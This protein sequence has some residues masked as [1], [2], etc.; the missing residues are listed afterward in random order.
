MR[1]GG[2]SVTA[3]CLEVEHGRI[4]RIFALRNPEELRPFEGC[5]RRR[6]PRSWSLARAEV[7]RPPSWDHAKAH[8]TSSPAYPR[9]IVVF[10]LR[11]AALAVT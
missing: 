5:R 8:T 11:L 4:A 3:L 7:A 9:P 6:R 10:R 1:E 2:R